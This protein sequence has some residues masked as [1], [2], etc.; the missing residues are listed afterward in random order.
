MSSIDFTPADLPEKGH[1]HLGG[2]IE[3]T[4]RQKSDGFMDWQVRQY[5]KV[6]ATSDQMS[7]LYEAAL[8]LG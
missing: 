5:G 8:G 3:L 2:G 4:F 6:V 1:W 7:D